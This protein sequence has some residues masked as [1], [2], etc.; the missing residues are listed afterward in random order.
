MKAEIRR[1]WSDFSQFCRNLG[2][3]N[4][5]EGG[6]NLAICAES[7]LNLSKYGTIQPNSGRTSQIPVKVAEIWPFVPNFDQFRQNLV[8]EIK[9]RY[10]MSPYSDKPVP[11]SGLFCENPAAV[12]DAGIRQSDTKILGPLAVDLGY[13][14]TQMSDGGGFLQTCIQVKSLNPEND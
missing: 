5:S 1:Q 2:W 10:R 6:R 13:Q 12:T 3:L 11:D 4:F 9:Q 7:Q 8:I 14:K